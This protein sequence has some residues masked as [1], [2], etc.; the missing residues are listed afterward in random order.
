MILTKIYSA[1]GCLERDGMAVTRRPFRPIHH[2][3][4]KESLVG[5]GSGVARPGEITLA[6]LGILFLDEIAEFSRGTLEALRQPI[7]DGEVR[8]SRVQATLNYPCR[9][10]LVAAMNPCPCG[11][12][13]TDQCRCTERDVTAIKRN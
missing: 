3:A 8:L 6:H 12:Y 7:E 2:T 13:G 9:F 4:S 5:G 1:C 11:F 10:T